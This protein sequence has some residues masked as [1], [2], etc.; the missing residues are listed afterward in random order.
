MKEEKDF[1]CVQMKSAIQQELLREERELG[2]EEARRRQWDLVI[3]DPVLG[4]F[5]R[6]RLPEKGQGQE[7]QAS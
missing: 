2:K 4:P 1:D 7:K 6:N 3:N 5:V